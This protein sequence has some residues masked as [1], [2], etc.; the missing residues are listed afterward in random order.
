MA[1]RKLKLKINLEE[2]FGIPVEN[3]ALR[4]AIGGRLI[5]KIVARTQGGT[6]VNGRS[7]KKYSKSYQDSLAF[8]VHGKGGNV[9]LTLS[10]DM[11]ASMQVGDSSPE[12]LTIEFPDETENAK[13]FNHN[14]GDTL[15][16]REFFGLTEEE[17][18]D[19]KEEF[20]ED[21]IDFAQFIET[22]D[23]AVTLRILD[24]LLSENE[25]S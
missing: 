7:F 9:D 21:V 24:R 12:R 5:E 8:K 11:L 1:T 20:Q 22:K 2:L 6:D 14:T 3:R 23:E 4:E 10:G 18:Q 19:V 16:K 25:A 13:A 17:K 15:P